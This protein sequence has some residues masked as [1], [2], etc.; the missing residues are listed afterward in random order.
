MSKKV[1]S[2]ILASVADIV[3]QGNVLTAAVGGMKFSVIS[4]KENWT[5]EAREKLGYILPQ[6]FKE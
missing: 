5:D 4:K 3:D 2:E 1:A 6:Y